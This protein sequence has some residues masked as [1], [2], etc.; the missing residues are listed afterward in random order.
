MQLIKVVHPYHKQDRTG[1]GVKLFL[2][3]SNREINDLLTGGSFL[4]F[5]VFKRWTVTEFTLKKALENPL[6]LQRL[7]N[8]QTIAIINLLKSIQRLEDIHRNINDLFVPTGLKNNQFITELGTQLNARNI[9]YP[10]RYLLLRRLTESDCRVEDFGDFSPDHLS[11][12]LGFYKFNPKHVDL[13]KTAITDV[14]ES[15]NVWLNETGN[16]FVVDTRA[17]RMSA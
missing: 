1:N 11:D 12:L 15:A 4:G 16:E 6:I 5:Q 8:H 7:E 2:N 13:L 17:F 3:Q 9:E 10:E 14:I